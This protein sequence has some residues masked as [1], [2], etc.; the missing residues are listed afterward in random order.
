MYLK[1]LSLLALLVVAAACSKKSNSDGAPRVVVTDNPSGDSDD[2]FVVDDDNT[3]S[4]EVG[5]GN[6]D[7]SADASTTS[8]G[9]KYF[10][11]YLDTVPNSKICRRELRERDVASLKYFFLQDIQSLDGPV[12][13]CLEKVDRLP[14]CATNYPQWPSDMPKMRLRIEYEDHFR[15]WYYDSAACDNYTKPLSVTGGSGSSSTEIVLM[16]GQGFIMAEG[17]KTT[18]GDYDVRVS[19]GDRP[20]YQAAVRYDQANGTHRA[21]TL[22]DQK[23]CNESTS[24]EAMINGEYCASKFILPYSFWNDFFTVE[25]LFKTNKL[26]VAKQY[27]KGQF[28][29][30]FQNLGVVWGTFGRV[31][32]SG[33]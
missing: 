31:S 29:T 23:M 26:A 27:A 17:F 30:Q 22:W 28:P 24:G 25:S 19:F 4:E 11:N 16:D 33:L 10:T 13:V 5:R 3:T 20:S 14:A 1:H 8:T 21:A 6:N 15:F 32:T 9:T 18:N 7:D 2:D 12:T